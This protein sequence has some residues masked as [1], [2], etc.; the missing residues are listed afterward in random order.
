V[1]VEYDGSVWRSDDG[2]M[3]WRQVGQ[4]PFE[5]ASSHHEDTILGPDGR[6]YV[7][8]GRPGP[9]VDNPEWVYRTVGPVVTAEEPGGPEDETGGRLEVRPN[10]VRG[11]AE[12]TFEVEA[13]ARV[14]VAVYDVLGREVAVLAD[15]RFEAGRYEATLDASGLAAG[16]Y[17]VRAT[18]VTAE[19]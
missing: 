10:P 2:A 18:V 14:R 6:L 5:D 9:T 16:L 19:S 8:A 13:A 17:L 11:G 4:I 1:V 3:T 7:A 12:V 15:G